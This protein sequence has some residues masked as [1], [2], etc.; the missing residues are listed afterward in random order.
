M[1]KAPNFSSL[2]KLQVRNQI[3]FSL[4]Y[5]ALGVYYCCNVD[6]FEFIIF[7]L[8]LEDI[9]NFKVRLFIRNNESLF[10]RS[11]NPTFPP[12]I[13]NYKPQ[14]LSLPAKISVN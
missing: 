5:V 14:P 8:I 2:I 10:R 13:T 6:L 9:L 12:S 3:F 7:I 11:S 1:N 4:R